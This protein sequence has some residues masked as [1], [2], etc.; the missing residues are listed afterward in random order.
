MATGNRALSL[1]V[2]LIGAVATRAHASGLERV[3]A[4]I[5]RLLSQIPEVLQRESSIT[6]RAIETGGEAIDLTR[7]SDP[8]RLEQRLRAILRAELRERAEQRAAL[9]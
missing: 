8:V 2:V 7:L 4:G 9:R 6:P 1:T 5:S 3:S